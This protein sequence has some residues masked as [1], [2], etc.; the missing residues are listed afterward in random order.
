MTSTASLVT[1]PSMAEDLHPYLAGAPVA[2]LTRHG[3][4][5][6]LAP[7]LEPALGV[8]L[9]HV[10][11][12]DTDTLGSFTRDVPRAGTQREAARRKARLGAELAGCRFAVAS[13]GAFVT[14]P[15]TGMLPWDIEMVLFLDVQTGLEITGMEQGGALNRH[16]LVSEWEALLDFAREAGFPEHALVM[17]PEHQDDPRILKGLDSEVALRQAFDVTRFLGASGRVFV[18]NDLRAHCHPG[19]REIIAKA[20]RNLV[21]RLQSCCP[22]CGQPDFWVTEL[23]EGLP[24][25]WCHE[26][27]P[28]IKA[29]R[30]QCPACQHTDIRPRPGE[31]FA[32]PARCG[33]C[34]P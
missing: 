5:T 10:D 16:R 8:R 30:W 20:A 23:I 12:I 26:P 2:L 17:R 24:C 32:D 6:L 7:V 19:R 21:E 29:E 3:K 25:R 13:E 28:Q 11:S 27:T 14:D 9:V 22:A 15:W 4:E 18:E 1:P 33:H 34:N 31:A